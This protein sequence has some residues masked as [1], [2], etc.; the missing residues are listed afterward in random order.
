[1]SCKARVRRGLRAY[2][3]RH[4]HLSQRSFLASM[5]LTCL[6]PRTRLNMLTTAG[7]EWTPLDALA[8][9]ATV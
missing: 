9:I 4:F 5:G 7:E 6:S 2:L 8:S 3:R 1:M